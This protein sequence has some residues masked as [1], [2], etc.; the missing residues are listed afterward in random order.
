[1]WQGPGSM[2]WAGQGPRG[3]PF[4]EHGLSSGSTAKDTEEAGLLTS[5]REPLT[6]LREPR[7]EA[8]GLH[9]VSEQAVC[10]GP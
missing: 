4:G 10:C 2:Q 3:R 7:R 6:I 8:K 1:M 5:H 9:A